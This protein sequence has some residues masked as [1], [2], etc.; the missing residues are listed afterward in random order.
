VVGFGVYVF[1]VEVE[2]V[3]DVGHADLLAAGKDF[4][5]SVLL[6]PLGEGGRHVHLLDDVAPAYASVVCAEADFTLLRGVGNDALLGA[7]EVVVEQILEPHAGDEK[8]VPAVLAAELDVFHGAV[9]LDA[10]VVFA[11]GVEGLVH[12]LH[13]VSDFEVGGRLEGIVVA[14]QREAETDGGEP[15]AAG[16][17]VDLGKIFGD[18]AHVEEGGYGSG[19]LGFLID[20]ERHA[21]AAVGM[22]TAGELTPLGAGSVNEIGPVRE[23]AHEADGEPVAGGLANAD[24]VLDVV[25]HVRERVALGEAALVRDVLVAACEADR[26]EAEEADLLRII[27]RELDDVADLL[28]IDAVDDRR[29]GNDIDAGFM[30]VVDGLELYVEQVADLAVRVGCVADA[31]ELKVDVA[32]A[33][34]GSGTAKLLGL[35]EFDAVARG[36]NAVVTDLAAVGYGVKE[37]GR[38]GWLATGEL[39]T[40]LPLGLDGDGVVEH[41]L[42]FVPGKLVDEADLI[43]VHEAGIAHHIAAVGEVDS[44]DRTAAMGH[45]RGA[46]VV[47]LLIVVGTHVAA[48][49]TFFQMLEEGGVDGHDVFKV[50][51]LGAILD[52]E[53]LAV[54][55]DNL[56]LDFAYF[57]VQQDFVG[58][59]AVENLLADLRHAFRTERVCGA[60][61]SEGRLF[62]LPALLERLVGPFGRERGIWADAVEPLINHP[63]TFGRVDGCFFDVFD[64]FGHFVA[65]SSFKKNSPA[66]GRSALFAVSGRKCLT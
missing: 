12:L 61:P 21:D 19:F 39:D 26:L 36:L 20:H 55:L 52:H 2:L 54:A 47:E 46:V 28:I 6:I 49:E 44:K 3:T 29:D 43:G 8:E 16:R 5:T 45:G 58:Q 60:R 40:H 50:A 24:L 62:L 18:C 1:H 32:E 17:V 42:D 38:Q 64:R 30:Q 34:F 41:G 23:G 66:H 10:A 31:V 59:L 9:A 7:A 48:W 4:V 11:G 65:V 15:L 22:A 13:H 53:D 57:F 56:G 25:R 37:V 14:H 35:G 27:Q 51:V 33:G 63:R